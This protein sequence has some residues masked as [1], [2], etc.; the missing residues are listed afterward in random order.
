MKKKLNEAGNFSKLTPEEIQT[1]RSY[2]SEFANSVGQVVGSLRSKGKKID[3]AQA[4][5]QLKQVGYNSPEIDKFM[6]ASTSGAPAKPSNL[7]APMQGIQKNPFQKR[8]SIP[9]SKIAPPEELGRQERG[10]TDKSLPIKQRLQQTK[11]R[12]TP[13]PSHDQYEAI[14]T[15]PNMSNDDVLA[16]QKAAQNGMPKPPITNRQQLKSKWS[17]PGQGQPKANP[18][19]KTQLPEA[20]NPSLI[21]GKL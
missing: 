9:G 10:M 20:I 6:Q 19:D 21:T 4:V 13:L 18:W 7:V 17:V 12:Q 14:R 1:L 5:G 2:S 11:Q 3:L 16:Q 8:D 15:N